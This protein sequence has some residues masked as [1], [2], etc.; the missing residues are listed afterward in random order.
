MII[1][2]KRRIQIILWKS[3]YHIICIYLYLNI[4]CHRVKNLFINLITKKRE[5]EININ[6]PDEKEGDVVLVL[7]TFYHILEP[8]HAGIFHLR[9]VYGSYIV[10]YVLLHSTYWLHRVEIYN[11]NCK[12][13]QIFRI[14]ISVTKLSVDSRVVVLQLLSHTSNTKYQAAK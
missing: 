1:F 7:A 3:K 5:N 14:K 10:I 2:V 13:G 11:R 4:I 9:S 6:I 12:Y 8:S